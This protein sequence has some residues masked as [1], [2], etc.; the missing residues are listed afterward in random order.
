MEFVFASGLDHGPI[1]QSDPG[2]AVS[3][4]PNS[5]LEWQTGISR[6][7]FGAYHAVGG[8]V[9]GDETIH[10]DAKR[11]PF[12]GLEVWAGAYRFTSFPT[13]NTDV[14]LLVTVPSDGAA[15][16]GNKPVATITT[17]GRLRLTSSNGNPG[18]F[19]ESQTVISPNTWYYLLLH[20]RNGVG[21]TQQLFL[22][23]GD[24]G[25]LLERLDLVLDVTGSFVNRLTKWGFGTS[26]DST[27]LEYYL[28]DLF[29]SRG[30]V[31]PGPIRVFP[32]QPAHSVDTGFQ[33]VGAAT[34]AEATDEWLPDGDSTYTKSLPAAGPQEVSFG[35]QASSLSLSNPVYAVQRTSIARYAQTLQV[36]AQVGIRIGGID[37]TNQVALQSTYNASRSVFTTNPRDGLPWSIQGVDGFE[38]VVKDTSGTTAELRFTSL[39]WDVVYGVRELPQ[40]SVLDPVAGESDVMATFTLTLDR[41]PDGGRLGR[42]RHRSFERELA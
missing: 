37:Y 4:S 19:V 5:V 12:G 38:G 21:Q 26:Q 2:M 39:W 23:D 13:A 14:W 36:A 24:S 18:Q 29:Q 35:L 11:L 30:S 9:Q 3:T 32:K 10:N 27:G 33:A 42:G 28:D 7:G 15:G 8:V 25:H 16:A 31:N 34:S 6:T 1:Q 22:Y 17:S 20:G 40:V 41:D